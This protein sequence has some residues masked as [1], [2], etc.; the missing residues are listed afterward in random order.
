M[1]EFDKCTC[2]KVNKEKMDLIKA[3]GLNL[4]DL[5]D[6]AMDE[7]LKLSEL[8][9]VQQ[10]VDDLTLKIERLKNER[11]E[12]INDCEKKIEILMKNLNESKDKEEDYYNKHIHF[13]ELELE[14]LKKHCM[15]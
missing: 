1:T 13:L 12:S 3:K 9:N 11:D 8:S 10:K 6:K 15:E 2:V 4:Q 14:Y 5:L 7:E